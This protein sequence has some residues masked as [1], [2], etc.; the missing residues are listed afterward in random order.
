[1]NILFHVRDRS[2][3]HPDI[4]PLDYCLWGY[5]KAHVYTDKPAFTVTVD[6]LEDNIEAFIREIPA[7][8]LEYAKIGLSGWTI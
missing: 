6:A 5:V 3:G 1:V 7:E 8:M 4:T 2:I